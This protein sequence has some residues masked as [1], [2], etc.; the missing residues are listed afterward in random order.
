[1]K[2]LIASILVALLV[3]PWLAHAADAPAGVGRA[4]RWQ[5]HPVVNGMSI[6]GGKPGSRS[7]N[8]IL[9]DTETGRTWILWP[10]KD[11]PPTGYSW[12]E[13]DQRK[14]AGQPPK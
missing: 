14:G 5:I 12:I 2:N 4:G 9:L 6:R 8:T 10:S 3:A 13:L 11:A 1:M 7:E